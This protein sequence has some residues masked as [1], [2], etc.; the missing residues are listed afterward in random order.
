MKKSLGSLAVI[1][2]SN[3]LSLHF[4]L[5]RVPSQISLNKANRHQSFPPGHALRCYWVWY[6]ILLS[7]IPSLSLLLLQLILFLSSYLDFLFLLSPMY[8]VFSESIEP[9]W[10]HHRGWA[11]SQ[12]DPS[13]LKDWWIRVGYE[14]TPGLGYV[15]TFFSPSSLSTFPGVWVMGTYGG[16][17]WSV[18]AIHRGLAVNSPWKHSGLLLSLSRNCRKQLHP[19]PPQVCP[20]LKALQSQYHYHGFYLQLYSTF[21]STHLKDISYIS[22]SAQCLPT[23][24]L[25]TPLVFP[26]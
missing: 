1:S 12:K 10:L 9:S 25:R 24:L 8:L 21:D 4:P 6:G 14:P 18:W 5:G 20:T 17:V 23:D 11:Q 26:R 15:W 19:A 7:H 3:R 2:L 22:S 13:W 16:S